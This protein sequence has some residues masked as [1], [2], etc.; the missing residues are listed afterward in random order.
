MSP[1]RFQIRFQRPPENDQ[2]DADLKEA[3]RRKTNLAIALIAVALLG[4]FLGV[5]IEALPHA[6]LLGQ[7]ILW[8]GLAGLMAGALLG[9][10]TQAERTFLAK[11]DAKKPPSF[12]NWRN[13]G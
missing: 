3:N 12:W 4:M 6:R 7:I 2:V 8:L 5:K 9:R 13:P 10:W 11:P 1:F